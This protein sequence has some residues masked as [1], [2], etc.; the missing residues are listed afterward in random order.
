MRIVV[1]LGLGVRDMYF[2]VLYIVLLPRKV[3]VFLWRKDLAV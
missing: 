1:C 3:D 2:G